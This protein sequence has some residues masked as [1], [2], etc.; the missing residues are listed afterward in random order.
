MTVAEPTGA[1]ASITLP[2][3]AE[4]M[5]PFSGQLESFT[6]FA[7]T[8]AG[9]AGLLCAA[10]W[11]LIA[12]HPELGNER[13]FARQLVMLGL[14]LLSLLAI[15]LTLPISDG[16]RNNLTGLIGIVLSGMLAFF[17]TTII[18]NLAAGMLIRITKPF[19][20]GDFIRI[21]QHFG[22]VTERG[23]FDTEI[24]S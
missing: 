18:A 20:T 13:K 1:P 14:T 6:P 12:R 2:R 24:Q 19:R 7:I 21:G 5:N 10:H 9:A 16:A 17:S 22:R 3:H 8:F 23:L 15:V 11:A 4:K